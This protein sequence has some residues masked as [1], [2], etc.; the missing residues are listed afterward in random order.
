MD[1]RLAIISERL[2]RVKRVIAVA[3][4]KG[5]VG[6]SVISTGLALILALKKKYKCGLLDL[7]FH[8]PSCHI[9]LGVDK[10]DIVEEKGIIP[11]VINGIRF[12][13]IIQFAEDKPVAL[14]GRDI[15]NAIIELL[16]ITRWGDLDYLIIDMP[17]GMGDEA[18]DTIRLMRNKEFLV[19][20]TPS[21]LS[22]GVVE[23]LI[24]FLRSVNADIIGIIE[25][26]ALSETSIVKEFSSRIGVRYLGKINY[27]PGLERCLGSVDCL[28]STKFIEN[29][30]EILEN[31]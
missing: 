20:T 28:M 3:S 9:I 21:K 22:I 15:S 24:S 17:P 10:L 13:S 26:M 2:S 19:I 18:L 30:Q 14:R 12:M 1:P 8:G 5:G 6:K 29:L 23:K 27:D 31:I 16:A 25:N 7:D 11:P 4:G